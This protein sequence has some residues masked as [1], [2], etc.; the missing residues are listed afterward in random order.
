M[1]S[2]SHTTP[3]PA[4]RFVNLFVVSCAI[5]ALTATSGCSRFKQKDYE[6]GGRIEQMPTEEIMAEKT[7]PAELPVPDEMPPDTPRPGAT[8]PLPEL[9]VIYFEYDQASLRADQLDAM[10]E[11]LK[12]LKANPGIKVLIEGH[13]D[14]RGAI[15]YNFALGDRRAAT[16]SDYYLKFGIAPERLM[17]ISKG[18]EEP[19]VLGHD[20]SAWKFNRR[21]EFKRVF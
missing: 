6:E 15:E 17:T 10:E 3:H 7:D 9:N 13:C 8:V 21:C 20:D 12:F 2:A 1:L 19:A 14:E 11:N 4:V 16:V 18:E 5:L